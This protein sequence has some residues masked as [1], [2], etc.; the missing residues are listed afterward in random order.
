MAFG[1]VQPQMKR[2][3]ECLVDEG[4]LTPE[5]VDQGLAAQRRL[6]SPLGETLISLGLVKPNDLGPILARSLGVTYLNPRDAEVDD[7]LVDTVPE[8]FIREHR[9][10]PLRV[11]DGHLFVATADPL[12]LG[13]IDDLKL[14]VRQPV[15]A[16]LS[17][18]RDLL[19]AINTQFDARRHAEEAIRD[20]DAERSAAGETKDEL[21]AEELSL[22]AADAPVVRLVNS[23]IH[24]AFTHGASD[25]HIEPQKE[26][27]RVRYRVDGLLYDHM[28][29][30]KQHQ[31]A[32]VSRIKIMARLNIAE[33]RLPQDGRVALNYQGKEYDL[34]VSTMP[35]M[36]GEKAV[37]RVL[38]KSS[39]RLSFEELGLLPGQQEGL[40][41]LV[42]RP[43]GMV[44]VTGP[45]GSGKSTTLY[46][47]LATINDPSR[48]VITIEDPIE[49]QL[50]GITQTEAN[51][52]VG[53]TFARGLRSMVRQDPDVIM[54]GEIRDLETAE[55][56]IQA[57]LTG[58]LVFSTLHTNDAP[59]AVV[60]LDHMGVEPFLISSAV[61][62]V[63]A[64]RLL[65]VVCPTCREWYTP[66]PAFLSQFRANGSPLPPDTQLA[67]GRGC[68]DCNN[69]GYRGRT[70][71]FEVLRM[72]DAIRELVL[73]RQSAAVVGEQ[74]RREG[75]K[76]MRESAVEKALKG[77]TSAEEILRVIYVE[78]QEQ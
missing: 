66:S 20:I 32:V 54:V 42:T 23:I 64:Q 49:Y 63:L 71:V 41:W 52:K 18:E 19:A 55:I 68:Q 2:L 35:S 39:V 76:T 53:M 69:V 6:G 65:R 15:V 47:A 57:A 78:E 27:T 38:D 75:M 44:L 33:R 46:A 30:P 31:A 67:R 59:G 73:K 1:R 28:I 10:L 34:R 77:I 51:A 24:G 14:I 70:A 22:L 25:I 12:D 13:V 9:I 7:S 50:P 21:S 40:R 16:V 5:Q 48:N 17:M 36:F 72:S 8:S 29:L 61:I 62:G 60:R 4:L 58:H 11:E 45:T 26:E 56:A 43:Y 37:M 3:G 74:A